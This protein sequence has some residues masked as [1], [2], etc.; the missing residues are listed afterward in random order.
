MNEDILPKIKRFVAN[1][2]ANYQRNGPFDHFHFCWGRE[3]S[4]KGLCDYYLDKP[5]DCQYFIISVLP[6]DPI[7]EVE[8][9]EDRR[10]TGGGGTF[11]VSESIKTDVPRMETPRLAVP[12]TRESGVLRR[13]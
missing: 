13:K 2:C 1:E 3:Y 11:E 5:K 7:L 4:Q 8:Y 12:K 10:T 9:H 6:I